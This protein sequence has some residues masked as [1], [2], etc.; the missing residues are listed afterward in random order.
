MNGA[1]LTGLELERSVRAQL[2]GEPGQVVATGVP[3]VRDDPRR[4]GLGRVLAG[5]YRLL[6]LLG[7]GGMATVYRTRDERLGRN[8]AIKVI[9]PGLVQDVVA[10]RRFRREAEL[11]A[12]LMH[13]NIVTVLDAGVEPQDF[14]AMEL[15][16]GVDA[17]T[18]ARRTGRLTT[19][20]AIRIV[21]PICDAL[22]FAHNEG[23]LHRDIKP[24]NILL[25]SKGRLKIADFGIAKLLDPELA[26]ETVEADQP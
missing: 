4:A 16:D 7:A 24:E 25:D 23:I 13:T 26:A 8:V 12:R 6:E 14:I 1:A 15:V 11:G 9:A 17:A 21:A 2:Y 18:L 10:V 5:R 20:H 19:H 22:Q 3:A